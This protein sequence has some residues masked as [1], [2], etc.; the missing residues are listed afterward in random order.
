MTENT[1]VVSCPHCKMPS[2]PNGTT[3]KCGSAEFVQQSGELKFQRTD[4]CIRIEK[5]QNYIE[6]LAEAIDGI[7]YN[8]RSAEHTM[9]QIREEEHERHA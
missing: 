9:D 6:E 7:D 5:L 3:F 2:S 8:V 4:A 1:V